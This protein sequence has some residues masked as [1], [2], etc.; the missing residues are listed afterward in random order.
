MS[1][2]RRI[3]T[4]G[5]D[6]AVTAPLYAGDPTSP[7]TGLTTVVLSIWRMNGVTIEW[8]DFNDA[9]FKAAGWTTLQQPMAEL[10]AVHAPGVYQYMWTTSSITNANPDDSYYYRVVD[11]SQQAENVPQEGMLDVGQWP[12]KLDSFVSTRATQA[13]ILSDAT[14]FPGANVDATISSRASALAV[15]AVQADTDDIQTRL[16]AALVGGRMDSSV[17]AMAAG[18][19][20]ASAFAADAIDA[21]AVA[22]SA[23]AEI[24]A[25]LATSVEIAA[26]QADTDDIQ[27]RLPAALI[28]GRMDSSV[29]AMAAGVLTE[30]AIAPGAI[31][32]LEAPA[33]ANLDVPVST[34]A[35]PGEGLTAA[36]AGQ[37]TDI[38][39]LEGLDKVGGPLLVSP[40]A[41]NAPGIIQ[42]IT[43]VGAAYIVKRL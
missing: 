19:L 28:G 35:A 37:L 17:G 42:T 12:D 24:Q 4:G 2:Y 8:Y 20:T 39:S 33:L 34:R 11:T 14:P 38:W 5:S 22:A 40:T 32:P 15:A 41:R 16:P 27:T 9:T 6:R 31:T 1:G 30:A 3:Q 21:N 36:Q 26:V 43:H 25:G 29:G 23:V 18:V 13:Q 10:D 7:L